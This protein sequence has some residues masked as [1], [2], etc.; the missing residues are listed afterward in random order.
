MSKTI[1]D[2]NKNSQYDAGLIVKEVHDY[3][4]QSIRT[5]DARSVVK[6]FFTHFRA[7]YNG[8][9]NP[10]VVNYYRGTK[11]HETNFSVA[12]S[13][14]LDGAYFVLRSAPD[15]QK[16]VV[17]YNVD[18]S[19]SQPVVADAKY[20]EIEINSSDT[21]TL[22]ALATSLTI[23]TLYK[24]YFVVTKNGTNLNI[25]TAQLGEVSDSDEGTTPF[26]FTQV[27]GT[28][29]LVTKI[30]ID[31]VANDPYFE[32]QVLK[33]YYYD[34]YSGKFLKKPEI[35]VDS[36][37][38]DLDASTSSVA[39]GDADGDELEINADGSINVNIVQTDQVLKSYFSQVTGVVTGMTEELVSYTAPADVYLQKIEFSGTNIAQFELTIDGSTVD[40]KRTFFNG[41]LENIF[42]FNAGLNVSS[43]SVVKVYVVHDRP[44][45][46]DFNARTQILE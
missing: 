10:T 4:G 35:N 23:N 12:A 45:P 41:N 8:S 37:D 15:N 22:I 5:A 21:G 17:W 39:I 3:Y 19:S 30:E 13:P 18:G 14:F 26:T 40:L 1:F 7:T 43:G 29:E 2:G 36:V 32:G 31:Y 34:I 16:W 9:S 46:G 27:A 25:V 42:D 11:A 6:N 28:Q 38:I 24:D 44:D 33:G 20:I